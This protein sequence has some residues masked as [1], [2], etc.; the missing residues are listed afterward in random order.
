SSSP[1]AATRTPAEIISS[2]N[3]PIESST[4]LKSTSLND[5]KASSL[6]RM[7][8]MYFTV[9]SWCVQV[10]FGPSHPEV[11]RRNRR[12]DIESR[13]I[14]GGTARS[15]DG[16]VLDELGPVQVGVQ[17]ALREQLGVGARLHDPPVVED[18]DDVGVAHGGQPVRDDQRGA[19]LEGG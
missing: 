19:A 8:S 12:I 6:A 1:S 16:D 3:R 15:G 5:S 9:V 17:P 11:E 2:L 14:R 13:P 4:T 10:P 7:I 18:Q